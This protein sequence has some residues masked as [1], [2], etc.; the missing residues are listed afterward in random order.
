MQN[1]IGVPNFVEPNE[2]FAKLLGESKSDTGNID[3]FV[4]DI[5]EKL[6]NLMRK[7]EEFK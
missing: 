4:K 6:S 3:N 2:A 5:K 7:I 1:S